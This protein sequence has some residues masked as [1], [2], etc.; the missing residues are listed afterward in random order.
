MPIQ[1][2]LVEDDAGLSALLVD[3]LGGYGIVTTPAGTAEAMK[4]LL[5]AGTPPPF[6]VLL[7][8]LMLPDGNGLDLCR[9]VRNHHALP[10]LML[11][12]QGDPGSRVVGLEMGADDYLPK[13]FE[14][15]ELVARV[16]AVLRRSVMA[17]V[18]PACG[19]R[20]QFQGWTLD[21]LQRQLVSPQQLV[22]ALSANEF[23]LL[24]VFLAH[25]RRVLARTELLSL[26][27]ADGAPMPTDEPAALRGVDLAVSRLRGKLGDPAREPL[28][29]R[30]VRGEGYFFDAEI[31]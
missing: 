11:T 24:S 2:L 15:R 28:L 8:D 13:P 19:L 16:Q 4:R 6:D 1:A 14:P 30:T 9:W 26:L 17:P 7:L 23:R 5:P 3:Y 21:R 12:A 27:R 18:P 29:I 22:L 31:T 10:I 25:P 20:L